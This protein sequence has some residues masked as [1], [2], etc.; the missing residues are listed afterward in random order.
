MS[1]DMPPNRNLQ[2]TLVPIEH[3]LVTS[4]NII[5]KWGSLRG[6]D[7][8]PFFDCIWD[9]DENQLK[10][11]LQSKKPT[12]NLQCI[13]Y[14]LYVRDMFSHDRHFKRFRYDSV[15][16]TIETFDGANNSTTMQS[17]YGEKVEELAGYLA[18]APVGTAAEDEEFL[19]I[20]KL[21]DIQDPRLRYKLG[22]YARKVAG[23]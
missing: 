10:I 9:D 14:D 1:I 17:S 7:N 22:R 5:D 23:M 20:M 8:N 15:F 12:P 11:E 6:G 13:E 18:S 2:Q 21:N 4:A 3:A 19:G 16:K